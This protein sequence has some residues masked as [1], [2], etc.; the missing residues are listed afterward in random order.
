[1]RLLRR[2]LAWVFQTNPEP[3]EFEDEDDRW[4]WGIR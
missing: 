3:R 1:M 2:L 4:F